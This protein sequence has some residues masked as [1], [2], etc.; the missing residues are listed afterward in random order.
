MGGGV[1]W[2]MK[3][4]IKLREKN[5]GADHGRGEERIEHGGFFPYTW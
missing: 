4:E 1:G 5:M 2:D 3:L